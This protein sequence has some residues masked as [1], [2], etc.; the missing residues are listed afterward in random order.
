MLSFI[1]PILKL[2]FLESHSI[3]GIPNIMPDVWTTPEVD[4]IETQNASHV[5]NTFQITTL[6]SVAYVTGASILVFKL[7]FSIFRIIRIKHNSGIHQIGRFKLVR[8]NH[9]SP[10]SFFNLIFMPKNETNPMI[11][12][13][14]MAHIKQFHWIDL[15]LVEVTSVLL[16]FNPFVVLYKSTLK[17]QH[18]YLADNNV[19]RDDN[20]IE[21]YLACMLKRI[22]FVSNGGL[23]SHFYCKT[24]KKRIIMITKH[25]TSVKYS[26][27][28]LLA[29]PLI[30]I[31]LV[32]FTG[33]TYKIAILP[34][35]VGT[36]IKHQPGSENSLSTNE[37]LPSIYPVDIKKITRTASG[38]GWRI[39]PKYKIRKFH[40][41]IDYATSEGEKVMS[42]AKG[43]VAKTEFGAKGM[44]NYVMIKHNDTYTTLYTH[45]KGISV[46]VGDQI[47]KGQIIGF[48]GNTGYATG[49]HL[50]YEVFKNG[51]NVN[52]QNY[53]P[54][55]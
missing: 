25:K 28:Y 36:I 14:E 40:C 19:V 4:F 10:F 50:H 6:L 30:F 23:V 53:L 24:I 11:L 13:H 43:T 20:Q 33:N 45:L 52:P 12:N 34:A 15:V 49:P 9:T 16:W 5:L 8:T 47:E 1:V 38:F 42:A 55:N 22:Q 17:L 2:S 44:G 39:H 31:L 7:L 3:A 35:K 26:G 51:K 32:A 37:Y 41:G 27:V 21:S 54:K 18:E 48:V 46:S 29:L